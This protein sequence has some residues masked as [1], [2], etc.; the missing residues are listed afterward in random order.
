MA[1]T[2][3]LRR[4]LKKVAEQYPKDRVVRNDLGRTTSWRASI[5]RPSSN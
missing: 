4:D 1:T 5:P 3:A 2:T